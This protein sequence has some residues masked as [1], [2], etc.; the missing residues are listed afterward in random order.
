MLDYPQIASNDQ[1]I[2]T[3]SQGKIDWASA[4]IPDIDRNYAAYSPNHQY[5]PEVSSVVSLL[6]NFDAPDQEVRQLIND[7]RFRRAL[8]MIIDRKL[9]I[10][11]AVFGQGEIAATPSGLEQDSAIGLTALTA[12]NTT[13]TSAIIQMQEK[14]CWMRWG[15][16]TAM[17]MD[18]GICLRA[19]LSTCRS[20][21]QKAGLI[22]IPPVKSLRKW[23]K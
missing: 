12:S 20:L 17:R 5:H 22:L 1:L 16:L 3:L 23:Q 2:D 4:F 8:S 21:L 14:N 7:V 10:N 11:I 9:L 15:L 6:L 13:I 19:V 18:I